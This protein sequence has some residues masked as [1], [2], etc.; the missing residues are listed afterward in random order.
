MSTG[1][2]R[3]LLLYS[4]RIRPGEHVLYGAENCGSRYLVVWILVKGSVREGDLD[5]KYVCLYSD[6]IKIGILKI[7]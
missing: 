7:V 2:V 6:D 3:E 5:I 1:L 4:R